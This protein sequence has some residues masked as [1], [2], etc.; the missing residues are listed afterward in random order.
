MPSQHSW[1]FL[2]Q[3][4][5][6]RSWLPIDSATV[7]ILEGRYRMMVRSSRKSAP[8]Q[9]KIVH[10]AVDEDPPV[11]RTQK[12]SLSTNDAGLMVVMPYTTLNPGRWEFHCA[13]GTEAERWKYGIQIQ[14]LRQEAADYESE[15][16]YDSAEEDEASELLVPHKI[17]ERQTDERFVAAD[18]L[19]NNNEEI[20]LPTIDSAI[21]KAS[22][23][24]SV[25]EMLLHFEEMSGQ[26]AD[27][28]LQ[29]Y[30]LFPQAQVE[31]P[32]VGIALPQVSV[33][34]LAIALE[35]DTFVVRKGD[36]FVLSGRLASID[37]EAVT[38]ES[39]KVRVILRDPQTSEVL[40]ETE[41]LLQNQVLPTDLTYWVTLPTRLKTRLVLGEIWLLDTTQSEPSLL[42]TQAFT[43]TADLAELLETI[44]EHR[45]Y[46]AERIEE[47]SP[48]PLSLTFLDFVDTAKPIQ[49]V[50]IDGIVAMPPRLA[51]EVK[52]DRAALDLPDFSK[53]EVVADAI[54]PKTIAPEPEPSKPEFSDSF[55]QDRVVEPVNSLAEDVDQIEI[56]DVEEDLLSPSEILLYKDANPALYEFV[57]DDEP[58]LPIAYLSFTRQ[59]KPENT[60]P[61]LLPEDEPVPTPRIILATRELVAGD[62]IDVRVKLPDLRPKVYV[63]LWISDRQSRLLLDRPCWLVDFVPDGFNHLEASM[64]LKV[65]MGSVGIEIQAIAVEMATQ[66]ESHKVSAE[67]LVL[68]SEQAQDAMSEFAP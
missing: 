39:A 1:E 34:P 36:T 55:L 31:Q 8:V 68:R 61:L 60:N 21:E 40:L 20:A 9:V 52:S 22:P 67:C 19:T 24:T 17:I 65:P 29:E 28:V 63:K 30:D 46:E 26:M 45:Q 58:I 57:V 43:L 37:A 13:S 23:K 66:R 11:R 49:A 41:E 35:Q 2:I 32:D 48:A 14:V 47:Q 25:E 62:S 59:P 4:D 51:P 15:W 50:P 3:K 12:R 56:P 7:E 33:V 53:R 44:Q 5:G 10:D 27:E 54:A 64:R 18:V 16:D 42:A 6:D 38:L